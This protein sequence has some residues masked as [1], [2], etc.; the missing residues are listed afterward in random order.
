[1]FSGVS[2]ALLYSLYH[3]PIRMRPFPWS[4]PLP[5][6]S[7]YCLFAI[8]L[9]TLGF[10]QPVGAQSTLALIPWPQQLEVHEGAWVM[11]PSTVI[12]RADSDESEAP[13]QLLRHY[14]HGATA[15]DLPILATAG[16]EDGTRLVFS[17]DET[18][19][20]EAYR[21]SVTEEEV[22]MVAA[23]APGWF[24]AVQT[25]RQLLPP[26]IEHTDYGLVRQ[27]IA[28]TVPRVSIEDQ[29]RFSYRGMHLDIARHFQGVPFIKEYIDLLARHKQNVFHWHL[30]EDQGWRIEIN[31][32][33]RLTEVGAFR[34]ETLIGRYGSD[35]YDGTRYGGF[36]TQDEVR[37]VVAFAT[38]RGV[39]V[40]PEIELPGHASAA[41]AAYPELGCTGGP[42]MVQTTWGIFE[43]VY[44]PTDTT[45][46]FLQNVLM[47]VMAL[48]PSK[49]IHIGG[50]EVPKSTWEASETVAALMAREGLA[51]QH[52][53]QSY[54]VQR[55]ERFLNG[56][57][58]Q[59]IGW[60]EILEGGLAPGAT[61]M[62]WRGIT[63]GLAA[64]RM[65]HDVVMTP[66][67][68]AYFDYYQAEKEGEPL[69]IGGFLPLEKVYSYEPIPEELEPEF[70]QYILGAQGNV[71][72]EYMRSEEKVWYMAFPRAL[73]MA[74]VG[75]LQPERK[76]FNHFQIRAKATLDRLRLRG[77]TGR[78]I[79]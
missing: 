46:T 58:R 39:T 38:A 65:Q 35:R 79:D 48:F 53:V 8:L 78:A 1:M 25:V 13:A 34:D 45:F 14:L 56:Y 15:F 3:L 28:W 27:D 29:P 69:A 4:H 74:E 59:I 12:V 18:L 70:H 63:G 5:R 7:V 20:P 41:L 55:I 40:I 30:T 24:H 2:L 71:W 51:D 66:T 49:Y 77:V 47:E 44:C 10:K 16:N 68:H 52:E 64:A 33:P 31:Q 43:D 9:A 75:W 21:I 42:Y 57:G 22:L 32:Y 19:Q 73:A 17:H 62:S 6:R 36:Y 26:E 60:D 76:N 54:F 37:E 11:T 72:T 50:D 23:S 61:V 67:S